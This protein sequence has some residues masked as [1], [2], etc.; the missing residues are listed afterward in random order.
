MPAPY[1]YRTFPLSALNES[2]SLVRVQCNYCKRAHVY[3]PDDL[4][5]IFGDV[6]VDSLMHRMRCEGGDHGPL[7][8]HG[9]IPTGSE[10]VG[11][12]IRRLVALKIRR[13]PVWRED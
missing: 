11:L 1:R 3:Y 10:A 7:D 13:V 5:Q 8:V 9:F 2:R 6:D 12:R 4:I